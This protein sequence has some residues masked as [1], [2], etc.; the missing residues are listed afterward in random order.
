LVVEHAGVDD[1]GQSAFEGAD[2]HHRGHPAGFAAVVVD[3]AVGGAAQWCHGHDVQRAVDAPVAGAGQTVSL[4]VAGRRRPGCGAVPGR[5]PVPAG[6]AVDAAV[7]GQQASRIGRADAMQIQQG[8]ATLDHQGDELFL[9][10]FD[11]AVDCL[12]LADQLHRQPA[13]GLAGHTARLDRRDQHTSLARGQELLGAPGKQLQQQPVQPIDRLGADTAQL[14]AAIG[15]HAQRQQIVI[16]LHAQQAAVVQGSH[17]HRMRIDRIGLTA[18]AGGED[19]HLRRQRR[20]HRRVRLGPCSPLP[21]K[22]TPGRLHKDE[23]I[24]S[25]TRR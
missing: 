2:G 14:V 9:D 24:A 21:A 25:T 7:I 5:G 15:E 19:P 23:L 17:R 10:R 1:V 18:I 22:A 8:R 3:A 6:E 13:A 4:L 16:D 12:E 20:C 11:L